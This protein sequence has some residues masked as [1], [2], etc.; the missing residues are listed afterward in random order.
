M[1]IIEVTEKIEELDNKIEEYNE[2][3]MFQELELEAYGQFLIRNRDYLP[4]KA[5][6]RIEFK[7]N[8]A[9]ELTNYYEIE[10]NSMC[11]TLEVFEKI[12]GGLN[13]KWK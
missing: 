1:E 7:I 2:Y 9:R 8:K 5:I 13:K 11:S 12:R 4:K 6:E 3:K 10:I